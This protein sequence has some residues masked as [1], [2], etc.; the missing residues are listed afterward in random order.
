MKVNELR[1]L[2]QE[3]LDTLEQYEDDR[4]IK[5]VSNTYF[6][7]GCQ[8]FLGV[9]GYDGGYINLSNLDEQMLDYEED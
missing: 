5:M 9:S 6:L 4:E 7:G 1:E 2:L 8:Y 3:K